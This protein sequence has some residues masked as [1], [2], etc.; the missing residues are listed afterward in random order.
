MTLNLLDIAKSIP[1]YFADSKS[2]N[3]RLSWTSADQQ[4]ELALWGKNLTDNET[5]GGIGG[6]AADVLGTPITS[7]NPP[8]TYGAE[9]RYQF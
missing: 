5:T 7:L 6:W 9:V 1:A 8:R 4:W 2:L 3:T